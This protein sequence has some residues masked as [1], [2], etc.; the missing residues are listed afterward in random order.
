M[1]EDKCVRAFILN[2]IIGLMEYI[3][4]ERAQ[5]TAGSSLLAVKEGHAE[6]RR[7]SSH[8]RDLMAI[9]TSRKRTIWGSYRCN[10]GRG[11][12]R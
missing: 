2:C 12:D 1:E 3:R 10:H 6:P 4:A 11:H 7:R 9:R 8:N 5:L